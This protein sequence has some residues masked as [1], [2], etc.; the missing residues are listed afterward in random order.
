MTRL[1]ID[2]RDTMR[3]KMRITKCGKQTTSHYSRSDGTEKLGNLQCPMLRR[4]H[5]VKLG[6]WF[7]KEKGKNK[8]SK[9]RRGF[10]HYTLCTQHG[11]PRLDH[12]CCKNVLY[13]DKEQGRWEHWQMNEVMLSISNTG[14]FICLVWKWS[15]SDVWTTYPRLIEESTRT[16]RSLFFSLF[17]SPRSCMDFDSPVVDW[18]NVEK[19]LTR[20]EAWDIHGFELPAARHKWFI[21]ASH[22]GYSTLSCA[23]CCMKW[24]TSNEYLRVRC[25]LMCC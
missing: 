17:W 7:K 8:C 2:D 25:I 21:S 4:R 12:E 9:S 18:C 22:P 24:N 15:V 23:M 13:L 19:K 14:S 16:A 10:R 6:V 1:A 11:N 3:N 5:V 20:D